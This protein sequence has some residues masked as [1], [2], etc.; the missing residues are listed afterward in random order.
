MVGVFEGLGIG[1]SSLLGL[2]TGSVVTAPAVHEI[3]DRINI[4]EAVVDNN[5]GIKLKLTFDFSIIM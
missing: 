4:I 3:A 1:V 2:S 5:R